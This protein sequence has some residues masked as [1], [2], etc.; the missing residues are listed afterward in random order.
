VQFSTATG[1]QKTHFTADLDFSF[2]VALKKTPVKHAA[3]KAHQP[4][5]LKSWPI[6]GSYHEPDFANLQ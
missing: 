3:S 5:N 4:R 6:S 2:S 1:S